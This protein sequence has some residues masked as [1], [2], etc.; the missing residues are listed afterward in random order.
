MKHIDVKCSFLWVL[1][2]VYTHI[3]SIQSK[4]QYIFITKGSFLPPL[5]VTPPH[6]DDYCPELYD[7]IVTVPALGLPMNGTT[8][9]LFF[10]VWLCLLSTQ[11]L[12]ASSILAGILAVCNNLLYKHHN[13][14]IHYLTDRHLGYFQLLAI[15]KSAVMD[16]LLL[17]FLWTCVLIS[18]R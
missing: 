15:S 5:A 10:G 16:V 3:T 11:W 7:H 2:T 14:V 8:E 17:V 6:R 4:T 18:L 1:T 12:C 9:C 13:L